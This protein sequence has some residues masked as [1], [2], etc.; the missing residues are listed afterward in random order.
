MREL[1]EALKKPMSPTTDAQTLAFVMSDQ[2]QELFSHVAISPPHANIED[3]TPKYYQ[4][5]E[6]MLGKPTVDT[7]KLM[8]T[9]RIKEVFRHLEQDDT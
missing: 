9:T 8:V 3:L 2:N 1:I 5:R 4:I 6:V 7:T